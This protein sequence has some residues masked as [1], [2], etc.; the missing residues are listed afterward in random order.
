VAGLPD[1]LRAMGVEVR[2]GCPVIGIDLPAVETSEGQWT[3]DR[4][5]VCSG[6]EFATLYPD[7]FAASGMTRCK[8]QMMRTAPQ[9]NGWDLGP[10]LAAGLTLRFYKAFRDCTT[11]PALR[12]R[13][14][15]DMPEYDRWGIHTLVSQ[16]A[17]GAITLGDSHEYGSSPEIF[18]RTEIDQL[19]L[20]NIKTYLALP[21]DRIVERWHGV[22][23]WHPELSVVRCEPAPG[24][25]IVTGVG[26]SGMTLSFGLAERTLT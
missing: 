12:A 17:D 7:V 10:A 25:Q 5:I 26:G 9:P 14:A 8:L 2:T 23:A 4:A 18:D 20:D 1:V 24:V 3:V 6:D 22:Y 16:T 21:D 11:L 13:I 19:I 15:R